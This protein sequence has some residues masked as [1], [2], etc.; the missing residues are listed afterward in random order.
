MNYEEPRANIFTYKPK[1]ISR[2]QIR[3]SNPICN[4]N[5]SNSSDFKGLPGFT[6]YHASWPKKLFLLL[7]SA[8][9]IWKISKSKNLPSDLK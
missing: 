5:P 9:T 3:E 6:H 8:G 7:L 1:N 2:E 4:V